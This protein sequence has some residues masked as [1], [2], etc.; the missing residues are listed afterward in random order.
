MH[1]PETADFPGRAISTCSDDNKSPAELPLMVLFTLFLG[2]D[3]PPM[4]NDD[5]PR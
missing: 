2:K 4:S 3:A 1:P 5:F